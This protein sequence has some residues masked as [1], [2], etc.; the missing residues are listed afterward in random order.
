MKIL[1]IL[2]SNYPDYVA[3]ISTHQVGVKY[4]YRFISSLSDV[5]GLHGGDIILTK[6]AKQHPEY[7]KIKDY[8]EG[9]GWEIEEE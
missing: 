6:N 9:A 8:C 4:K 1:H 2:S 7:K 3:Y 5:R